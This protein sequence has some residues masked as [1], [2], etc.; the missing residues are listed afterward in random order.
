M[1]EY[2]EVEEGEEKK[3]P[4]PMDLD[5][6][7][8]A[9]LSLEDLNL[10]CGTVG[11]LEKALTVNHEDDLELQKK[12]K[13]LGVME[14]DPESSTRFMRIP[15]VHNLVEQIIREYDPFGI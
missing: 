4:Y 13:D 12:I 14:K 8:M 11:F 3:L 1:G 15:Y 5:E 6:R 9:S 2:V 7:S 10:L